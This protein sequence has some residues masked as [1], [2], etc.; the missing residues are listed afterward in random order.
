MCIRD[1]LLRVLQEGTFLPVGAT[2]SKKVDVRVVAATNKDLKEM[3]E[4]GTFREDLYYRINVINVVVPPLRDRKDDIPIL[5]EHFIA[6]ACKEKGLPTKQLS[7]RG[8]EKVFD[9]PWPGNIRELQNE[10]ERVVVLAGEE[11]RIQAEVLSP[12]IREYGEKS[13][14]Q[15]VR[16]SGKLKD[17]LEEL[18]KTMI[19]LSLIHISI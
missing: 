17:A 13:K 2:E 4:N 7:R 3:I 9:Y 15:G 14:V 10:M 11:E 1:R 8:L 16:V 12:R 6:K 19:R 18:E 5:V